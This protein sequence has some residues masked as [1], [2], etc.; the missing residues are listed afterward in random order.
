MK[1]THYVPAAGERQVRSRTSA[2]TVRRWAA[3]AFPAVAMSTLVTAFVV[4]ALGGVVRV[5][6]SGLGCPDWPL[7]HGRVI[8]PADTGAWIE[9]T[10]RLSA[11]VVGLLTGMLVLTGFGRYHLRDKALYL[12]LLVP[13]LVVIQAGLGAWTVL[14]ELS[15]MIA[16]AH[17]G[18]AMALV[19]TLGLVVAGARG[20]RLLPE[21]HDSGQGHRYRM[22][23]AVLALASFLLILSGAY[24][25]RSGASL[26]CLGF[27]HCG[28]LV[29]SG[30][31]Q[32]LQTIQMLHR[33]VAF[34]VVGL[35]LWVLWA[36]W[37]L[38]PGAARIRALS[39]AIAGALALQVALGI[40][41]VLLRL[42][43]WSR[44]GHVTTSALFFAGVMLLVGTAWS[45]SM[46]EARVRTGEGRRRAV[47][48]N[49]KGTLGAY[50]QLTKPKI[51]FLL[52]LTTLGAML[53]AGKGTV[54]W[55]L[56][57]ATLTAGSL[58]A[59]G[60]GAVNS[61]LDRD[62]D[63]VMERTRKRPLPLGK[64]RPRSALW[65]G[66]ALGLGSVL[67]F[68]FFVN[69]IAAILAAVAWV[70][71]VLGYSMYLKHRTPQNIVIGGAA[72]A[73]PPLI[74]W[75]AVTGSLELEGIFL[76]LI[77][78]FW[79]PP[80]A[81]ALALL[82]QE[83]Y[84]KARIP[85]LPVV[86]GERETGRQILRYSLLLV[87][88]T[89]V[90]VALGLFGVLY[91]AATLLLGSLLVAFAVGVWLQPKRLQALR[92]FRYST[93]YLALLFLVLV[94]DRTYLA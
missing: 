3:G 4:V 81:W 53:A 41:N 66:V 43:D 20:A 28:T 51:V 48:L 12:L 76:F 93:L 11:V 67:L 42:P 24:V 14:E 26:A 36:S 83:D 49:W 77:I 90:P 10:H 80:H 8:P 31:V 2:Q 40:S 89:S 94:L 1:L 55:P 63:R 47:L 86:Q 92:L 6:G 71:Y 58:C 30:E 56:L 91:L 84:R 54:S 7:C 57:V 29:E 16:L 61:Y 15:P 68:A 33:L 75:T 82:A 13:V 60:A 38:G 50:L 21:V 87:V 45:A 44:L 25:T 52:L 72:G 73:F 35:T 88:V 5:T 39:L 18:L 59:G 22:M 64:V 9:Y 27:P 79:T 23:L 17:T 74:G 19:G 69:Q 62:A 85:M 37:R 70:Y 46:G 78:F 32:R 65:F 34:S